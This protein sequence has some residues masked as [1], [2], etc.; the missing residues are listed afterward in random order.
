MVNPAPFASL[1]ALIPA[2]ESPALSWSEKQRKLVE[3][4]YGR[5]ANY[6]KLDSHWKICNSYNHKTTVQKQTAFA[7]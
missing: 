4:V 2:Q 1:T 5:M 6:L 3:T 7:R